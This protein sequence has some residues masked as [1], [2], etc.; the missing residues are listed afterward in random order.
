LADVTNPA[1]TNPAI[2]TLSE[3]YLNFS[4]TIKT[5]KT[6]ANYIQALKYYMHFSG[7]RIMMNSF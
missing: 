2:P 1:S 7:V 5:P 4:Q 6:R 3:S